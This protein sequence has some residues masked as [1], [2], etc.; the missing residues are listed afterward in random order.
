MNKLEY[1]WLSKIDISNKNKRLL[2]NKFGGIKRL[3][4]SSLDDFAYFEINDNI[5][6]KILNKKTKEEALIDFEYMKK[7]N[8]DII[9]LEDED[10]PEKFKNIK[11]SPICFYIKGNRKILNNKAVGIVGSRIALNESLEVS[12]ILANYL[13]SKGF[14]I[15]SGLAKGIDKYAHLGALEKKCRG[16]TI[17]VLACR[18]R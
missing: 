7:N 12:K 2:I 15:I 6:Y 3:F 4:K 17:G 9:T 10:Y 11:D 5:A 18:I 16:K 1:I 13:S 8:I 14:N